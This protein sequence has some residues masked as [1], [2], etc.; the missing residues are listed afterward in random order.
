[1]PR[2]EDNGQPIK[3]LSTP[4]FTA[5]ASA[6]PVPSI[7]IFMLSDHN[8]SFSQRQNPNLKRR[9]DPLGGSSIQKTVLVLSGK[10]EVDIQIREILDML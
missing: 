1:M 9:A 7:L 10:T 8:E 2:L 3:P 5:P 4:L 6:I